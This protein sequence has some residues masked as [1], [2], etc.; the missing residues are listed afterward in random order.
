MVKHWNKLIGAGFKEFMAAKYPMIQQAIDDNVDDAELDMLIKLHHTAEDDDGYHQ[1]L[2]D[3]IF[4][5]LSE[6]ISQEIDN[7]VIKSIKGK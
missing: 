2:N 1:A 4:K 3:E 6:T 5:I 7:E